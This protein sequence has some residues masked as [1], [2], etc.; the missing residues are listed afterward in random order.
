MKKEMEKQDRERRKEEQRIIRERQ[1]KEERFQREER[2]EMER[3]ERFMQKELLR[4]SFRAFL[5]SRLASLDIWYLTT[6][7]FSLLCSLG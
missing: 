5:F 6:N 1:R 2:R 7:I 3:R 4:V